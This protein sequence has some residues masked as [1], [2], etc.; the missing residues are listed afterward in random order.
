VCVGRRISGATFRP[1]LHTHT[2]SLTHSHSRAHPP[3]SEPV[4]VDDERL[5][6]SRGGLRALPATFTNHGPIPARIPTH[7]NPKAVTHTLSLSVSLSLAHSLITNP[8]M[9]PTQRNI[10]TRTAHTSSHTHSRPRTHAHTHTRTHTHTLSLSWEK[11]CG[12]ISQKIGES[13]GREEEAPCGN[14]VCRG[15][16]GGQASGLDDV[17]SWP[18]QAR[19]RTSRSSTSSVSQRSPSCDDV[20]EMY[21][22]MTLTLT[23]IVN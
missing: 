15:E 17:Q 9:S 2:L 4:C 1:L 6:D 18:H 10:T 11:S 12:S 13:R 22:L 7:C 5:G 8:G 23:L 14:G 20:C 16:V 19:S 21:V 3:G